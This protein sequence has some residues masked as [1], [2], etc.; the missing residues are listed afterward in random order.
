MATK[1]VVPGVPPTGALVARPLYTRLPPV[2][3]RGRCLPLAT[4]TTW[5]KSRSFGFFQ[6]TLA[7]EPWTSASTAAGLAGAVASRPGAFGTV[8]LAAA[9]AAERL[10]AA[11][12]ASTVYAYVAPGVRPVSLQVRTVAATAQTCSPLERRRT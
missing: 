4:T 7:F 2:A 11:S 9:P 12:T 8:A 6:V 1:T 3:L 5:S 10:P